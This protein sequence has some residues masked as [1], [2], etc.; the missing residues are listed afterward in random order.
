MESLLRPAQHVPIRSRADVLVVG[1]GVDALL[2]TRAVAPVMENGRRITRTLR[3]P[4][5][6]VDYRWTI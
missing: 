4:R 6:G 2:Y 3:L 1:A 5:N